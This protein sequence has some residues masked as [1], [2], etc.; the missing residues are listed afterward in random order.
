MYIG[1]G[2]IALERERYHFID[3]KKTDQFF[4]AYCNVRYYNALM[5]SRNKKE[6]SRIYCTK[7]YA[8]DEGEREDNH[9]QLF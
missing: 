8:F 1:R 3:G 6:M 5:S 2:N 4:S 7:G 9:V